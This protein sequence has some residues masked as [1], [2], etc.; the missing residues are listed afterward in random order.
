MAKNFRPDVAVLDIGLPAM[1][2]YELAR[3]L[4]ADASGQNLRLIASTGYVEAQHR[5]RSFDAGFGHHL[6]KPLDL[7]A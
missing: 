3:R 1:D 7:R 4:S 5:S 2:G 6:A